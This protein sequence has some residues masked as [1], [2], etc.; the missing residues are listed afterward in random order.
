MAKAK[1]TPR[2]RDSKKINRKRAVRKWYQTSMRRFIIVVGVLGLSFLVAG[3][4]WFTHSGKLSQTVTALNDRFFQLTSQAGFKV[5]N[6]NLEGH[7][8]T[9]IADITKA[10]NVKSGDPILGISL[11]DI[12]A[13]L[14]AIPRVK[15]AEVARILPNELDVHI[16]ER[17]PAAIW[18]NEGKLHLIDQDGVVMEYIDPAQYKQ[19]LLVVGEDAPSH[20]HALLETLALEPELYQEITAAVWVGERRWN[21]RFKN[22]IELKLPEEKTAQAWQNFAKLNQE[23]HLLDRAIQSVDMRLAD[24][25]FIKSATPT[26]TAKPD[27]AGGRE[28]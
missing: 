17:A 7:K 28:T 6:I 4:W 3:G 20:A 24:R 26:A 5:E 9:D 22:G 12:R 23:N 16:V 27:K 25:V 15:Y 13:R 10:L 1:L 11:A 2:Q 14:E 18:Q 19:L 8:F 21:I